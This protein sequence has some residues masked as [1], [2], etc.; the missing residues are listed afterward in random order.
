MRTKLLKGI[1]IALI[2]AM[3]TASLAGCTTSKS[4]V[5]T[6]T[7]DGNKILFTYDGEK[8]TLKEGWLYAKMT[9]AQLE[10][11]Y[12]QY[13]GTAFWKM[14][15]GEDSSGKEVT[16]EEY[17][18]QNVITQIKQSIILNKKAK[19]YGCELTAAEKKDSVEAALS[20]YESEDGKEIMRECGATREDVEKI[21]QDATVASKV[22][23][24]VKAQSKVKVTDDEA[25]KSTIQRIVFTKTKTDATGN[26]VEK[27]K[28]EKAVVKKKAK[29]ILKEIQ[30]GK[31]TIKEAAKERNY[32][33]VKESY[34]SGESEEGKS[35]EKAMKKLKDGQVANKVFD[36]DNGY[37]IAKLVA[38][39]DKKETETHRKEV[40]EQ[41]QKAA[42]EKEYSKW[43]KNLE[44]K[45]SY[46]KDV[47]QKLWKQVHL[48]SEA[49][50]E[51]TTEAKS[52]IIEVK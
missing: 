34:A 10:D 37:V 33:S 31:K 20:Y 17:T 30:S 40:K 16:F 7:S 5:G 50:A 1:S 15:M 9:A 12:K 11:S 3:L 24:K 52:N 25:R 28:K 42:F 29:K 22:E 19:E 27:S 23:E 13:Y 26:I 38:Y 32:T 8:V 14:N 6:Q 51:S 2:G 41:K 44:K 18:K 35:F 36:C 4:G 21:Y 39:T 45:W 49:A 46:S 47:D 48:S 43:T